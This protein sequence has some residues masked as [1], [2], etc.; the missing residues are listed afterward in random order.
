MINASLMENGP[1][2]WFSGLM[3]PMLSMDTLHNHG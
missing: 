1:V 3:P 2:P